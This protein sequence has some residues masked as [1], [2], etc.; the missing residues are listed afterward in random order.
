[1]SQAGSL[2]GSSG[3]L[4]PIVATS[5]VTNNGIAIPAVN[6]L[7]VVGGVGITT[8]GAGNT[9]TIKLANSGQ[10]FTT[11][12]GAVTNDVIIINM[13]ATPSVGV[14]VSRVVGFAS[15]GSG[16]SCG[17]VLTGCAETDGIAASLIS[18][19]S[20]L[21]FQEAAFITAD[22]NITTSGNNAQIS[23]LGVAGFT[24]DWTIE[25]TFTAS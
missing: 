10:A 4:P 15:G 19:Q 14:F 20:K 17:F 22:A 16:N 7:N 23:V 18:A 11:T 6:I 2:G 21:P 1:M 25:T 24:I 9:L 3:P 5:Y 8:E 12:I 13:G